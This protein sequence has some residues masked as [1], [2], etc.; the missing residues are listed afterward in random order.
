MQTQDI[1]IDKILSG[2][3][4]KQ[5]NEMQQASLEAAETY[6]NVILLSDTGSGKT[7][8][9]L[10]PIFKK[11]DPENKGTQALII[12][13]SRELALQIEDVF[14][15]MQTGFKVTCCYGGHL[16]ET[17]ENNLKQAPAVIIGTSGRLADHIRRGNITLDTIENL[18]LDE[19]DKSLELGFQ[20]ELKFIIGSL[21][22][23]KK[24][25]LTSA[26]DEKGIP[27]FIGMKSPKKLNFLTGKKEDNVL[28]IQTIFSPEKDKIETLFKLVCFFNQ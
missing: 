7:L 20:E 2:L 27:D 26:T 4:I 23:I 24:R 9:F 12:A 21:P 1:Q 13:P 25:M 11:L 22:N 17:E 6:E 10:L 3:K 5:L 18:V 14:K 19:F 16:R 28:T 15:K 8:A